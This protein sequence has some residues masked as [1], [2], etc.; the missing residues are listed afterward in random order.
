ME[1]GLL[2]STRAELNCFIRHVTFHI[3]FLFAMCN[4][5]IMISDIDM[6]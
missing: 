5:I 1:P 3:V 6:V 2:L 4:S